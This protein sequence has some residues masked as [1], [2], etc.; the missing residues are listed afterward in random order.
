FSGGASLEL[1]PSRIV[2][3]PAMV[4]PYVEQFSFSVQRQLNNFSQLIVNYTHQR[5]VHLLRG[6]NINAP[7]ASGL[8]PDPAEGNVEQIE[9]T[10]NS[11]LNGLMIN[12]NMANP[13]KRFFF[14]LN[15][16]LSKT[17][18][19]SDSP[20][21]LPANN[22]DLRAERGPSATDSRHR[23]F[24]LGNISVPYGFRISGMFHVRSAAPYTITTGF[25]DNRD[26]VSNDRPAGVG[27]NGARGAAEWDLSTRVGWGVG[28]GKAKE[29]GGGRP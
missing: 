21:S 29:G 17:T 14:A 23:L 12:A 4:M 7:L 2:R 24:A 26:T 18:N 10:A 8:R 5:G 3:D 22:F 1:P 11:T 25:D 28:W 15:Y 20:L 19:D 13:Q 9:S 6:H 27:R 16:F